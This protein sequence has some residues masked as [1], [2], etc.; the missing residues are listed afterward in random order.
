MRAQ[1][2]LT[3][4]ITSSSPPI[5]AIYQPSRRDTP[6]SMRLAMTNGTISSIT[7][8]NHLNRGPKIT[9]FLY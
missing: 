5:L 2:K 8:S 1:P 6:M 9:C 4:A 3:A 7:A